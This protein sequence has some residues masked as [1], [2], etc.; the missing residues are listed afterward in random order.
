MKKEIEEII[1]KLAGD[2][3][4]TK[5]IHKGWAE[6]SRIPKEK[7]KDF[8]LIGTEGLVKKWQYI[9]ES[10]KGKISLVNILVNFE[11]SRNKGFM[12]EIYCLNGKLFDDVERFDTKKQAVKRI[13]ELL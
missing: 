1:T 8:K 10:P 2:I 12:W 5:Q 11:K 9:Y 13:Y 3:V 4:V 6:W 7:R